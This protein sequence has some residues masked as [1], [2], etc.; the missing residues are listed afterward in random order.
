MSLFKIYKQ[1]QALSVL[2]LMLPVAILFSACLKED[3]LYT[4]KEGTC[5]MPQAYQDNNI[6][7]TLLK[8]D[9]VQEVAFGF[10]YTTFHGAPEEITGT[11][12]IDTSLVKVYNEENAFTGNVYKV[13]PDSVYTLTGT[14]TVVKPGKS[15]S[16]PLAI[17]INP[18]DLSLNEKYMLPI[19]LVSVSSG[20][21]ASHL[22][23]TYFR[24][25]ELGIRA[26]NITKEATISGSHNDSPPNENMPKLIDDN[27]D[28]KYLAFD[29]TPDFYV[30]LAFPK[31]R[32]IDGYSI[33]SGNDAQGRDPRDFS[34][35]GSNDGVNWT[36]LDSR[37]N[38]L[39]PG[40]KETRRFNLDWP[41]EYQYYRFNVTS[42]LKDNII[43]M[44]EL[45]LLDY[46]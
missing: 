26:R 24:I 37:T 29:Y 20:T 35:E 42:T 25:D 33:T 13:L 39:F 1:H 36:T 30:Q 22:A 6:I 34:L 17:A 21:I 18:K 3:E 5:Y 44:T 10:Y 9:S 7:T 32:E 2:W 14:T 11:F 16:E 4:P 15:S 28:T 45:G 43:Q 23:T 31:P 12:E 41:V 19:K 8:A 40:R 27:H 46:Y 38:E